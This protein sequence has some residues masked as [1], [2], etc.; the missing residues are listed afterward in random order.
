MSQVLKGHQAYSKQRRRKI[1]STKE[2]YVKVL[3]AKARDP[4]L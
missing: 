1:Y 3:P 4:K 2:E